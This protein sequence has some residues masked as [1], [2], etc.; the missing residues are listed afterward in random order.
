MLTR[1]GLMRA[2]LASA[3]VPILA[4][5]PPIAR[6]KSRKAEARPIPNAERLA[7]VE[8]ARGLMRE[9]HLDAIALGG[10]SSLVYF[11]GIRW[12]VSERLFLMILPAAGEPFF[13]SPGFEQGRALEQIGGGPFP[14]ARIL[15]WEEDVSPF[16][17]VAKALADRKLTTARIGVE[18]RMPFV[19]ADGIG[20]ALPAAM[21][22]SATPVTA[23]CRMIK[24]ANELALMHLANQVTLEAFEAAWKSVRDGMT[25]HEF[26]AA[27]AAAHQGLGFDGEADVFVGEGAALPHGSRRPQAIREN[28]LVLIDG[29]CQVEGYHSDITRTFVYGK[30][31]DKM[32]RVF[33]IVRQA[34]SAALAAARPGVRCESV[35]KAARQVIT[36]AGY[37]P[38]YKYFTHRIGHGIG[39]DE[40]EWPY[41]TAANTL[42]K[43]GQGIALAPDMT[44][45]D[46]PGIYIPGE[47]G[48]RLED[49]MHILEG[50]AELFTAQ[51]TSLEAPFGNR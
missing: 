29:G 40:H 51:S 19:F 37:G 17:V 2:A 28:S 12:G 23:G 24:S 39:L 9:N 41:L 15:T 14:T 45:S 26:A 32:K 10:G 1:R 11:S 44:F 7:R 4:D 5:T 3:A 38:G 13:V 50:R 20:K 8:R 48:I 47:F 30:A 31:T 21:M 27:I 33:D 35:D 49:D 36:A 18:E 43:D 6:L 42:Q 16:P 22:V 34:Q 46:E 25:A